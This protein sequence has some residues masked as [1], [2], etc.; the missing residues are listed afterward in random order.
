MPE[1]RIKEPVAFKEGAG[2]LCA[3]IVVLSYV[4]MGF[5]QIAVEA[6]L[7]VKV[8]VPGDWGAAMLSLASAALG[9]L[10][11]KRDKSDTAPSEALIQAALESSPPPKIVQPIVVQPVT[12]A[13]GQPPLAPIK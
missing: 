8:T 6:T 4:A 11:G 5:V 12:E 3:F 10:V 2:V 9:F 7:G 1:G 13:S